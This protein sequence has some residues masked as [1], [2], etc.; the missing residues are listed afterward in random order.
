MAQPVN[1][2]A[3]RHDLHPGANTRRTR[4]NPHQAEIAVLKCFEYSAQCR[5]RHGLAAVSRW[6][7]YLRTSTHSPASLKPESRPEQV[8]PA[9]HRLSRARLG[10]APGARI[11][12][13]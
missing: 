5:S 2:P 10:R 6:T 4:P 12:T 13:L 11:I 9:S 8:A 3:L 7:I 1:Q